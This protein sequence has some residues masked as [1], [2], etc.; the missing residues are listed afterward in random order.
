MMTM[1]AKALDVTGEELRFAKA[2]ELMQQNATWRRICNAAGKVLAYALPSGEK[3]G[4]WYEVTPRSCTCPDAKYRQVTCKHMTAV[5]L[6]V[7]MKRAE[8]TQRKSGA[9]A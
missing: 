8:A 1:T 7:E 6:Y 9:A 2:I 4:V 3:P 5:N